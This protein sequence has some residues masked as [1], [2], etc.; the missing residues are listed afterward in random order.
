[1]NNPKPEKHQKL[2]FLFLVFGIIFFP[3]CDGP[4]SDCEEYYF[5]DQFKA[6]CDFREGSYWV[7]KDTVYNVTDS[8]YLNHR[9]ISFIDECDY[10]TLPGEILENKMSSSYF[11]PDE[12]YINIEGRAQY[13][14]TYNFHSRLG[15]GYYTE[16]ILLEDIDSITVHGRWFRNIKKVKHGGSEYYWARDIGL[17]K[18][19]INWPVKSDTFYHFELVRY[20]INN[21]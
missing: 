21:Q 6:Y 5:S 12:E 14:N 16:N 10:N 7:Y 19:I 4:Y 1:M 20:H 13:N 8:C 3:S 2:L 17:V 18:K 11:H 15:F 9:S